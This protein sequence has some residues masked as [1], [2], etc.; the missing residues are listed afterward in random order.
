MYNYYVY[1]HF[2]SKQLI[3]NMCSTLAWINKKNLY[4]GRIQ[5]PLIAPCRWKGFARRMETMATFLTLPMFMFLSRERRDGAVLTVSAGLRALKCNCFTLRLQKTVS[6]MQ[7]GR[8]Q[9]QHRSTAVFSFAL[10]EDV[11]VGL[12]CMTPTPLQLLYQSF[13]L[14][15]LCID[16]QIKWYVK[17]QTLGLLSCLFALRFCH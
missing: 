17:T 6:N 12:R 16:V 3:S 11:V 15:K 8:V 10:Q 2:L 13:S 14:L 4:G 7:A 9:P 1:F 5:P